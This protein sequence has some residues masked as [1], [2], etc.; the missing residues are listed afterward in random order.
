MVVI[1]NYQFLGAQ[2]NAMY[3][4]NR[5]FFMN[6]LNWLVE[7]KDSISIRPK[8]LAR[9]MLALTQT[10]SMIYA[11]IA[12]ILIPLLSLGAGLVIWLRRR[13]L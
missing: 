5:D 6:S 11:G 4:G 2:I 7:R 9:P 1:S 12:V 10:R 3:P 13:H 8:S